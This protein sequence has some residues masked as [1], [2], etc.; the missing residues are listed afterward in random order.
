MENQ[1]IPTIETI[2]QRFTNLETKVDVVDKQVDDVES[3]LGLRIKEVKDDL[4]DNIKEVKDDLTDNIRDIKNDLKDNIKEVN[5]ELKETKRELKE[6]ISGKQTNLKTYIGFFIAG[7]TIVVPV[8]LKFLE[9][10]IKQ[11]SP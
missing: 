10:V 5:T 11:L 9:F 1:N 7:A 2:E 3:R 8:L 4:T 6:E